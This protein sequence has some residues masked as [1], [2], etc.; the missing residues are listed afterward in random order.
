MVD[1]GCVV[2]LRCVL[3]AL[4]LQWLGSSRWGAGAWLD[5]SALFG[6]GPPARCAGWRGAPPFL[7]GTAPRVV[8]PAKAAEHARPPVSLGFWSSLFGTLIHQAGVGPA[9][10]YFLCFAKESNQRKA[11]P[12]E[13]IALLRSALSPAL[14]AR[15]G[16]C[17]S[18]QTRRVANFAGACSEVHPQPSDSP[19]RHPRAGLRYSALLTG[20]SRALRGWRGASSIG[21][22][23]R[24]RAPGRRPGEGRDP[25]T[26]LLA[27]L[28]KVG[29]RIEWAVQFARLNGLLSSNSSSVASIPPVSRRR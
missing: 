23:F 1:G 9:A 15:R 18:C 5:Y 12:G 28:H 10:S 24:H 14:L 27:S 26:L 21:L 16:G 17:R 29:E 2:G 7:Y 3:S 25:V 19:R 11:T 20:D 13:R 4:C 6:E 8:V 22:L